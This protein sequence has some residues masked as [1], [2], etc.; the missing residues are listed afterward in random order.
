MPSVDTSRKRP[1]DGGPA[2]ARPHKRRSQ[3]APVAS[4]NPAFAEES[5]TPALISLADGSR[6]YSEFKGDIGDGIC[7]TLSGG[8]ALFP[9]NYK[10]DLPYQPAWI[11]PLYR[12]RLRFDQCSS[13]GLH[14]SKA[15]RGLKLYDEAQRSLF[16]VIG[17]RTKPDADGR[18]RPIV[19]ARGF[20]APGRDHDQQAPAAPTANRPATKT[21]ISTR[22]PVP[23]VK[24]SASQPITPAQ[25]IRSSSHKVIDISSNDEDVKPVV[26]NTPV[27]SSAP[28]VSAQQEQTRREIGNNGTASRV[29]HAATFEAYN[30][31]ELG[32]AHHHRTIFARWK[33]EADALNLEDSSS[34]SS[35]EEDDDLGAFH[36]RPSGLPAPRNKAPQHPKINTDASPI[37]LAGSKQPSVPSESSKLSDH[38]KS[39]IW[40]YLMTLT[41][42]EIPIPD[43][44]AIVELLALPMRRD[45]P[46]TW[47]RRLSKFEEFQL[48][49]LTKLILYL[50]GVEGPSNPC[51]DCR[52]HPEAHLFWKA[53]FYHGN[54]VDHRY[55]FPKCVF[56]P[57]NF[58]DSASITER[59]GHRSCC[60]E[61]HR[62][63]KK[64]PHWKNAVPNGSRS[65]EVARE[66]AGM[67]VMKTTSTN[68]SD[69]TQLRASIPSNRLHNATSTTKAGNNAVQ[70]LSSQASLPARSP[71][72]PAAMVRDTTTSRSSAQQ[73]ASQSA[74]KGHTGN[75]SGFE[76]SPVNRNVGANNWLQ[77]VRNKGKEKKTERKTAHQ[78]EGLG[79]EER[80]SSARQAQVTQVSSA[81]VSLSSL[82]VQD[83]PMAPSTTKQQDVHVP[84][85][86]Q[87]GAIFDPANKS[88]QFIGFPGEK[89]QLLQ[90]SRRYTLECT[91]MAGSMK[92]QMIKTGGMATASRVNGGETWTIEPDSQCLVSNFSPADEE[93][94]VLKIKSQPVLASM[95]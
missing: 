57:N 20:G 23:V 1:G 27:R 53:N 4:S 72:Q 86:S 37:S 47:Q 93:T 76:S 89:A 8:G 64:V 91:V 19:V 13:L 10:L 75:K 21:A 82:T 50:G 29:R 90:A 26:K 17:K 67:D 48:N 80:H 94:A 25:A 59:L 62:R 14:F 16:H 35:S 88:A 87:E 58:H 15:H 81:A 36:S 92:V 79:V 2:D 56:L 84:G 43:D 51:D 66:A 68:K 70:P 9:T 41:K 61:Y 63:W 18:L 34:T 85:N 44:R 60:N 55:P 65:L 52:V 83:T 42:T 22:T 33:Q 24:S 12:C 49:T 77:G 40:R 11:C 5:D 69:G 45:L 46:R 71:L 78:E 74:V 28:R 54:H 31:Q 32:A 6:R 95:E 73:A 7:R 3:G 39:A 30:S 38:S